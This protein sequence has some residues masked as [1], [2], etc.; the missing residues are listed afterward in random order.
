MSDAT[1]QGQLPVTPPFYIG[2]RKQ[3]PA[4]LASFLRGRLVVL[5]AVAAAI[6][7]LLVTAQRPFADATFEYG[8]TRTFEGLLGESPYPTLLLANPAHGLPS[9]VYLV[10]PGKHGAQEIVAGHEGRRVRLQGSLIRRDRQAM[11]EVAPGSLVDLAAGPGAATEALGDF[12]L[13]GE[14]VDSK[15]Y[16]GVMKPGN[17]KPHKAC[18]IRCISGGITPVLCVRDAAG[19]AAYLMLAGAD[20]RAVNREVLDF[21]AEPVEITGAVERRDNLLVLK[22]DPA[23]Y[24]RR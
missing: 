11:I 13:R 15:C 8:V 7:T 9:R 3:M 18:A 4:T 24:R 19:Q 20:G 5:V 10:A 16:L 21:V 2:Y 12:T 17:L 6:A 22:A 14:I 23:T 1:P